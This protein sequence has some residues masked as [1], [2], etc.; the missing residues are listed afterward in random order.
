MAQEIQIQIESTP[1]PKTLKF[2]TSTNLLAAGGRDF[3]T[4]DRA[5]SSPLARRVF[6]LDGV[7]GVY[8]GTNF[9]TVTK[10]DTADWQR[11]TPVIVESIVTHLKAGE[12]ILGDEGAHAHAGEG[13]DDVTRRIKE[14]LDEYVRPAVAQDGGDVIFDSFEDGVV[15]LH[16]QGSCSGCPSSTATLKNGIQNMLIEQ[17]PEVREVVQV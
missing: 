7:D 9:V 11:I 2:V 16:L 4:V 10:M 17:V 3:P 14:V 12:P 5:L 6:D 8:I 1:N 13:D 15:R